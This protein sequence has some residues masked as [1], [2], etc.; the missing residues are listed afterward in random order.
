MSDTLWGVS[1]H[2]STQCFEV[3]VYSKNCVAQESII[4]CLWRIYSQSDSSESRSTYVYLLLFHSYM[5]Y[6]ACP[7][8]SMH[9]VDT[10]SGT[11]HPGA[12]S[13]SLMYTRHTSSLSFCFDTS[14]ICRWTFVVGRAE[15]AMECVIGPRALPR[16]PVFTSVPPRL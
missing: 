15:R 16:R 11:A 10:A 7:A 4:A 14:S 1:G 8:E 3:L 9:A 5:Q 2:L 12:P 6:A 13:N